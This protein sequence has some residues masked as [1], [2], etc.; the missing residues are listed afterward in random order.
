MTHGPSLVSPS[1][2]SDLSPKGDLILHGP[3]APSTSR[4]TAQSSPSTLGPDAPSSSRSDIP[5]QIDNFNVVVQ[6]SSPDDTC[7]SLP[8]GPSIDFVPQRSTRNKKAS[9]MLRDYDCNAIF[10]TSRISHSSFASPTSSNLSGK[11]LYP[12]SDFVD[13]NNFSHH[14]GIC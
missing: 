4:A 12:L 7:T 14:I 13:Y 5:T 3:A 6:P 1:L 10:S 11:Y 9:V 8:A 2:A